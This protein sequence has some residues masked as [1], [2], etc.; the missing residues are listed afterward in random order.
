M[1]TKKL[2]CAT[3][4]LYQLEIMGSQDNN[5]F[6]SLCLIA[7]YPSSE[8]HNSSLSSLSNASVPWLSFEL[9]LCCFPSGYKVL[10]PCWL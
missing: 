8:L 2:T 9:Q 4:V 7:D 10:V 3:L 5:N 1:T 6:P